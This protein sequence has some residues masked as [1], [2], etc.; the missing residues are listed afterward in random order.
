MWPR[1]CPWPPRARTTGLSELVISTFVGAR[2]IAEADSVG[3][4]ANTQAATPISNS[5]FMWNSPQ[6][7]VIATRNECSRDPGVPVARRKT[8]PAVAHGD[9][10]RALEVGDRLAAAGVGQG[11]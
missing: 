2:G 4:A 3:T 6:G 7:R 1:P 9:E 10:L 8:D 11:E 5:R